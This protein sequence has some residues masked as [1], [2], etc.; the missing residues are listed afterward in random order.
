MDLTMA[1][2]AAAEDDEVWLTTTLAPREPRSRAMAA[3]MPL[4]GSNTISCH[5]MQQIEHGASFM[6]YLDEPVTSAVLPTRFREK[7][8]RASEDDVLAA[9]EVEAIILVRDIEDY[10][11]LLLKVI[12]SVCDTAEREQAIL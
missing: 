9:G 3:P 6:W 11:R 1:S 12:Q 7:E 5:D 4:E 2:P 10:G 8:G